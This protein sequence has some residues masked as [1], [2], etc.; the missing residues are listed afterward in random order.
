[1]NTTTS[2]AV[3]LQASITDFTGTESVISDQLLIQ[4]Q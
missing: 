2:L 3:S 1:M 4:L